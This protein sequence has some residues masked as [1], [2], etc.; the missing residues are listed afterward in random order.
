MA[1]QPIE[2]WSPNPKGKLFQRVTFQKDIQVG[3]DKITAELNNYLTYKK[4]LWIIEGETQNAQTQ[5]LSGLIVNS[6]YLSI[7]TNSVDKF[8][9]GDILW[10]QS[11]RYPQGRY[12]IIT[13]PVKETRANFPKDCLVSQHISLKGLM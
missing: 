5:P 12:F 9:Q 2:M 11:G 13:D 7:K 3:D 1:Q 6:E 4:F 10:L 8:E